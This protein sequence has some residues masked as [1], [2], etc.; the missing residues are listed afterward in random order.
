MVAI[1]LLSRLFLVG[2][3]PS[4]EALSTP[5]PGTQAL[6]LYDLAMIHKEIDLGPIVLDVPGKDLRICRLE[7]DLLQAQLI[8]YLGDHIGSPGPHV[9]RDAFGFDH[10]HVGA[11]LKKTFCL[12]NHPARIVRP[13][14]LKRFSGR[15][16]TGAELDPDL[17][18]GPQT[19][20]LDL[21]DYP[22]PVIR[23]KGNEASRD[24]DDIKPYLLA[25]PDVLLD[26]IPSL[27]QHVLDE[28]AG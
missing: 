18:L 24:L 1:T 20:L 13:G 12:L 21:L 28:P 3:Y 22:Q 26:R 2:E 25:L 5:D 27:S 6:E 9:F 4:P 11:G 14:R 17:G 7:H 15:R 23:G 10:D 16:P 8:D 19:G